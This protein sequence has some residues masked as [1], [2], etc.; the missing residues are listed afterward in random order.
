MT[1]EELAK[2][3]SKT[4]L[5]LLLSADARCDALTA[6]RDGL[7]R[8][9]TDNHVAL[10]RAEKAEA[11]NARLREVLKPFAAKANGYDGIP[12]AKYWGDTS[13]VMRY[14]DDEE[15]SVTLG[16]L[17]KAR[18]ALTGKADQA[19]AG[20]VLDCVCGMGFGPCKDPE[21]KAPILTGKEPSHE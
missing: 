12:P 8:C 6:E 9:V 13:F 18:A 11:D 21:C 20:A 2:H 4:L 14:Y 1:E 5:Q 7:L 15:V 3:D 10:C 16:N 17:R 19:V